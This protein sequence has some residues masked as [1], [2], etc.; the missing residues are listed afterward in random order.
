MIFIANWRIITT[1]LITKSK[2]NLLK[3]TARTKSIIPYHTIKRLQLQTHLWSNLRWSTISS[4]DS[5]VENQVRLSSLGTSLIS[6]LT[7]TSLFHV[8]Q[9]GLITHKVSAWH[10]LVDRPFSGPLPIEY[11]PLFLYHLSK[12]RRNVT[13]QIIVPKY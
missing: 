12:K 4:Y 7:N 6:K 10:R 3:E 5:N 13:N 2:S 1:M 8:V 11:C 9:V